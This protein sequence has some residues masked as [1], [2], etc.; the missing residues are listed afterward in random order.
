MNFQTGAFRHALSICFQKKKI[1]FITAFKKGG[2]EKINQI[3]IF[4]QVIHSSFKLGAFGYALSPL[5]GTSKNHSLLF[6]KKEQKKKKIFSK[7][8]WLSCIKFSN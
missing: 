7:D 4:F 5:S 3:K 1:T 8:E 2:A 6:K